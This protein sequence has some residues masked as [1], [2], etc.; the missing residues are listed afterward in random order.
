MYRVL[1]YN[2]GFITNHKDQFIFKQ[3]T[4]DMDMQNEST[5]TWWTVDMVVIYL[6]KMTDTDY[7]GNV[8]K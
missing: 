5:K 6:Y 3:Y 7:L 1:L 8:S 4:T 2:S